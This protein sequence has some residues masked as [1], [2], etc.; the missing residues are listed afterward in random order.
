MKYCWINFSDN[1]SQNKLN[2]FD[3]WKYF[4]T[5]K[6]LDQKEYFDLTKDCENIIV[7]EENNN[8]KENEI[9]LV[10]DHIN[11]SGFN[12]LIGKNNE[13]YGQRFS[14]MS[15]PY[16]ID[17]NINEVVNISLLPKIVIAVGKINYNGQ[18]LLNTPNIVYQSIIA[19]H[20]E[21]PFYG[22]V[23]SK[24]NGINDFLKLIKINS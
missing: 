9:F 22:F 16:L 6:Y 7:T 24:K 15:F 3:D 11:N 19:N 4:Q 5:D 1:K 20:Q 21:R 23:I 12:P 17:N 8:V 13:K 10:R 14:D 2:L 18:L